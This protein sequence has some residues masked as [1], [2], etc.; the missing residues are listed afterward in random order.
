M[1]RRPFFRRFPHFAVLRGSS[2]PSAGTKGLQAT[3][4]SNPCRASICYPLK[5]PSMDFSMDRRFPLEIYALLSRP[6]W[7]NTGRQE[8]R[9]N[10]VIPKQRT[11]IPG[12]DPG[13]VKAKSMTFI[14]KNSIVTPCHHTHPAKQFMPNKK[15]QKKSK[16][17]EKFP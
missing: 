14:P 9:K 3:R 13:S 4:C 6:P 10:P 15:T 8:S 12:P 1:A 2:R 7:L 11:V 17:K 16:K 5:N